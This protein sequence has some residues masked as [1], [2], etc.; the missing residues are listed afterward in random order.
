MARTKKT[1]QQKLADAKAKPGLPK[2]F[3]CEKS[4][5]RLVVPSPGEVEEIIARVPRGRVITIQQVG[6]RLKEVHGADAACPMTTGI[7]AWIIA[8]AAEEQAAALGGKAAVPWWRLLK[9]GGELNPK[10]PGGGLTQQERL[11]AE[12]HRVIAKGKKLIV[13]DYEGSLY[14]MG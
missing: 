9:T 3:Y 13:A 6:L 7:F 5:Q 10:Y 11:Q 8:N 12:G 1:W 14:A 4:R 2:V